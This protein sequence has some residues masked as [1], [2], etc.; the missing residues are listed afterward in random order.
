MDVAQ[1]LADPHTHHRGMVV[2][3]EGY[4][5]VA[6]PIKLARTPASYRLPPPA[7]GD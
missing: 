2:A 4:R 3:I 7:R 5:G 6:S 1:A